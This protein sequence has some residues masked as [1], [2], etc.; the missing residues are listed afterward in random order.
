MDLLQT[1]LTESVRSTLQDIVETGPSR[2]ISEAFSSKLLKTYYQRTSYYFLFRANC[3]VTSVPFGEL[4]SLLRYY[5]SPL[6]KKIQISFHSSRALRKDIEN[7]WDSVIGTTPQYAEIVEA[8][9]KLNSILERSNTEPENI[10]QYAEKLVE[11]ASNEKF[12]EILNSLAVNSASKICELHG[13]TLRG[14]ILLDAYFCGCAV[15]LSGDVNIDINNIVGRS[16]YIHDGGRLLYIRSSAKVQRSEI[17]SCLSAYHGAYCTTHRCDPKTLR[18]PMALV[19]NEHFDPYE[20]PGTSNEAKINISDIKI[21]KDK[22][23][24]AGKPAADFWDE[25]ATSPHEGKHIVALPG[26]QD[27]HKEIESFFKSNP[28]PNKECLFLLREFGVANDLTRSAQQYLILYSRS[29]RNSS[30]FLLFDE[31]KPGWYAPVTAPHTLVSAMLNL[32]LR[33]PGTKILTVCDPFV[34]SGTTILEAMRL[35]GAIK[36]V[37][38]DLAKPATIARQDNFTFF[39]LPYLANGELEENDLNNGELDENDAAKA[40]TL[41]HKPFSKIGI[42]EIP[43]SIHSLRKLAEFDDRHG[44]EKKEEFI[45]LVAAALSKAASFTYRENLKANNGH[46]FATCLK[47]VLTA[48]AFEFVRNKPEEARAQAGARSM[49]EHDFTPVIEQ[50]EGE[51]LFPARI[52]FYICWRSILRLGY[53][54]YQGRVD[55]TILG[56]AMIQ[57]F[58]VFAD[59]ARK[60]EYIRKQKPDTALSPDQRLSTQFGWYSAETIVPASTLLNRPAFELVDMGEANALDVLAENKKKIDLLVTDPPYGFNTDGENT[61]DLYKKLPEAIVSALA[62]NGQAV[63]CLP[64]QSHN[65]QLIPSYAQKAWFVREMIAAASREKGGA[66]LINISETN[67]S[68]RSL[69]LAPYYWRSGRALTRSVLHFRLIR[70]KSL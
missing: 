65:G 10:Q 47:W 69:F 14:L 2:D 22:Y 12:Q 63:I 68:L 17:V 5:S 52:F 15:S 32:G 29:I 67:P 9:G 24:I 31:S 13:A 60:L 36:F 18:L 25:L 16:G 33:R 44:R 26:L 56:N 39:S 37:A 53:S 50:L 55:A 40:T 48:A 11:V 28:I 49:R 34:G 58:N 6:Q 20:L 35:P 38:G 62:N 1:A 21:P 42:D 4:R 7:I 51:R 61:I 66:Q 27:P 57:D 43:R 46:P 3:N 30:P 59:Q 8:S 23:F 54:L 19:A 64:Q 45:A 70:N 41:L